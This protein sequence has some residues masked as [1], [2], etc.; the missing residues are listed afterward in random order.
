MKKNTILSFFCFSIVFFAFCCGVKTP[1]KLPKKKTAHITHLKAEVMDKKIKLSWICKGRVD[2]FKILRH[3]AKIKEVCAGCPL[4]LK[5]IAIVKDKPWFDVDIKPG[6]IYWY[7]VC[8]VYKG[9]TG[10]CSEQ[11]EVVIPLQ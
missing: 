11:V 3:Q 5:E 7:Q 6:Y 9:N 10:I 4:S 8:P 1:L 2:K